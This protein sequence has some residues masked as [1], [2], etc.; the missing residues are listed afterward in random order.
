V[1]TEAL[2]MNRGK[3]GFKAERL[4]DYSPETRERTRLAV[5]R[6]KAGDREALKF[7]YVTYSPNVY[8]YVRSIVHDDHE[9]EDVTQQAFAKLM[10]CFAKYDERDVPFVAWLLRLARNLSLDHVRARR[11]PSADSLHGQ[12]VVSDPELDRPEIVR[13]A[14]RS[15]SA[16]QRK[17][18]FLRHVVGLSPPEIAEQMGRTPGSVHGLHYRARHTLQREL[19]RMQ[20]GPLTRT[21]R[22]LIAA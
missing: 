16:D 7:L 4:V 15:L 9:A 1:I 6:A 12:H 11:I 22:R 20:A 5:Q 3:I 14:F 18:V 19:E 8:G 21:K 2:S 13:V 10:T 17:V